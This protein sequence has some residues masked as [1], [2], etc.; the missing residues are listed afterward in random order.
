MKELKNLSLGCDRK[1]I[2]GGFFFD[3]LYVAFFR[4][5]KILHDTKQMVLAF[6]GLNRVAES[7]ILI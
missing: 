7:F 6:V 2:E 3:M 5:G 1:L 4:D